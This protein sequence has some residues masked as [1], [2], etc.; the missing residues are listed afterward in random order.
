MAI[1][2]HEPTIGARRSL[3][4]RLLVIV[5]FCTLWLRLW[6]MQVLQVDQH[7][8][9]VL[10]N[11]LIPH[12]IGA[13]RGCIYDRDLVP[14]ADNRPSWAVVV[15]PSRVPAYRGGAPRPEAFYSIAAELGRIFSRS[16]LSVEE[17]MRRMTDGLPSDALTPR[18]V[19]DNVEEATRSRIKELGPELE[20]VD[21]IQRYVRDYPHPHGAN[22]YHVVGYASRLTA[23]QVKQGKLSEG[24]EYSD[25]IGQLGVE[26]AY[27]RELRGTKGHE[28]I[29]ARGLPVTASAPRAGHDLVLGVDSALQAA[30]EQALEQ[31]AKHQ[32]QRSAA[33]IVMDCRN[34][35][36]LAMASYPSFRAEWCVPQATPEDR[37]AF[38]EEQSAPGNPWMNHAITG[39]RFPASTFKIV[40]MASALEMSAFLGLDTFGPN[41]RVYCTGRILVGER[42]EPK[43]CWKRNGHGWVGLREAIAESCN[44]MFYSAGAVLHAAGGGDGVL[45]QQGARAFGFGS[46]TGIDLGGEYEGLVGDRD[47]RVRQSYVQDNMEVGWYVGDTMNMAIGHGDLDATP[48][49]V[50]SATAVIAN[51]GVLVWPHVVKEIRAGDQPV[52]YRYPF[53][54][55]PPNT[56]RPITLSGQTLSIIRDGMRMAVTSRRGTAFQAFQPFTRVAVAGKTGT[57]E[58]TNNSW[59]TSFAPYGDPKIVVTVFIEKGGHG[60]ASAAPAAR[61]I[62]EAAFDESGRLRVDLDI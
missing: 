37:K 51:G 50:A 27:E 62:Y 38:T 25:I 39:K 6:Q 36:V 17:I 59:F 41:K 52:E 1:T 16:D 20:G 22:A 35:Q 26:A 46:K 23:E 53:P 58:R 40:T 14:L 48:I 60:S 19:V 5:A 4:L 32:G 9:T 56:P 57:D 33:A 43:Y 44:T 11:V 3:L 49:Q 29:D 7:T 45:L 42:K 54:D 24:Y 21:V 30:A 12:S 61:E 18:L 31:W 10:D 55:D 8:Q 15:T 47:W 28:K 13:P 2:T 34:G